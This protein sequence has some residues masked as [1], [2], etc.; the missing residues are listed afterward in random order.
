MMSCGLRGEGWEA[1]R[2]PVHVDGT[3]DDGAVEVDAGVD[4]TGYVSSRLR[5]RQLLQGEDPG[6]HRMVAD[7]LRREERCDHMPRNVEVTARLLASG[8]AHQV[9]VALDP[10]NLRVIAVVGKRARR[11][12]GALRVAVQLVGRVNRRSDRIGHQ[13][14]AARSSS[15]GWPGSA[16]PA[17]AGWCS[18]TASGSG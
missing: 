10:R 15:G 17:D 8:Y 1:Q 18:K 11:V 2:S 4:E 6:V 12:E 16:F 13:I 9:I 14:R 3:R 7:A 5:S